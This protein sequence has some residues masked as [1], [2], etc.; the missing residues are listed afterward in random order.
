MAELGPI[1]GCCREV[2]FIIELEKWPLS[3]GYNKSERMDCPAVIQKSGYCREVA[4]AESWPLVEV[5]HGVHSCTC[6]QRIN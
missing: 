2:I 1:I 6:T 3:R 4:V 5:V